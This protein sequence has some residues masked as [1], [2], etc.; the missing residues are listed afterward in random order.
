MGKAIQPTCPNRP[1][2]PSPTCRHPI[3]R[4]RRSNAGPNSLTQP[5]A[6]RLPVLPFK[7]RDTRPK[8]KQSSSPAK[9]YKFWTKSGAILQ[10]SVTFWC[11][12]TSIQPSL[13]FLCSDPVLFAQIHSN[14]PKIYFPPSRRFAQ[15]RWYWVRSDLDLH[16][17]GYSW[18]DWA[19]IYSNSV[20]IR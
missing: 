15:I 9:Y 14:P 5:H 19:P 10:D 4:L 8:P 1:T 16:K 18:L 7:T 12:S 6:G 20:I 3:Q 2:R 17:S 11:S 13:V